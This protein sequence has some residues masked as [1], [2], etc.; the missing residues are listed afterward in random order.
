MRK[1]L[2]MAS[3]STGRQ[4]YEEARES[5]ESR[6]DFA[7]ALRRTMRSLYLREAGHHQYIL[8]PHE[9]GV[10]GVLCKPAVDPGTKGA[11]SD[12]M[13]LWRAISAPV[14]PQDPLCRLTLG[15]GYCHFNRTHIKRTEAI[16]CL[17]ACLAVE[18]PEERRCR[19]IQQVD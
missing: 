18:V 2:T 14:I 6:L 17:S 10:R 11:I 15:I 1:C 19:L 3:H 4:T 9:D 7:G 12:S 8:L 13:D 5:V 16:T